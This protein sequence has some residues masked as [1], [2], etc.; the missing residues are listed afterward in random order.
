[1]PSM[2]EGIEEQSQLDFV[3]RYRCTYVQGFLLDPI[4]E[5]GMP[6]LS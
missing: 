1:M 2:A 3:R 5:C 4:Q 6:H